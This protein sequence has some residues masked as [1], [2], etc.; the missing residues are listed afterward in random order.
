MRWMRA[1]RLLALL[2]LLLPTA[3]TAGEANALRGFP[4]VIDG[5]TL[6]LEGQRLT[7]YGIDAPEL[8]QECSLRGKVFDCGDIS[9]AA[10]LD[11]TAGTEIECRLSTARPEAA[12]CFAD[13]YDLAAGMV[14]TGWAL[15]DR[16]VT[17]RYA[18]TEARAASAKRGLWRGRFVAPWDW[19]SGKR[20]ENTAEAA[21]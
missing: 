18:K 14:Y 15:A 16:G 20:L 1:L 4:A 9:R 3:A 19:R 5:N 2:G 17:E 12:E 13:D 6:E 8:G 11:L 7:L 10:L 21:E